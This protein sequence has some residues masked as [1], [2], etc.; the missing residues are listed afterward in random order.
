ML[1]MYSGWDTDSIVQQSLRVHQMRIDTQFRQKTILQWRHETH[2]GIKDQITSLR[3]TFLSSLGS[4]TMMQKSTYNSTVASVTGKNAGAVTIRT[5][6]NS[7]VGSLTIG[8]I[9]SLARGAN[10]SSS[11]SVSKDGTGFS[12]SA[13][14]EDLT[15]SNGEKIIFDEEG[16]AT[17]TINGATIDLNKDDTINSMINKVNRSEADVTMSYD[18]LADRFTLEGKV[19]E[20]PAFGISDENGGNAL[21]L[22]F[23]LDT[24]NTVKG[25]SEARVWINNELVKSKTNTFDFRGM[26][27]TLNRTTEGSGAGSI[28]TADDNINVELKR[29][30]TNAFNKIKEFIDAYNSIIKRIEGLVRERKSTTEASY[31][32]LTDEERSAMSEKQIADWE[33]IAKKGILKNDN[34]LQS[35]ATALRSALMESVE[36]TGLRPSDIGLSTGNFFSGTGGQIIIDEDKLKAALEADPERVA[37]IFTKIVDDSGKNTGTGFL[38]KVD[39]IMRDYVNKGQTLTLKNLEDSIRRANEQMLKLQQRMYAEEDKL[40]KQFASMETA[41]SKMQSQGDWM[42]AMLGGNK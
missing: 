24:G 18:R 34:G 6:I 4:S 26:S 16:K 30:A 23:N 19:V 39:N 28:W 32:P 33:A 2:N 38:Y 13:K 25:G 27:I 40:Y 21:D 9:E 11:A 37:D 22:M 29:D 14:L 20:G 36:G 15:F 5:S 12:P 10:I 31:G 3:N 42:T 8:K 35:L 1:G 17:V 41:L 7:T